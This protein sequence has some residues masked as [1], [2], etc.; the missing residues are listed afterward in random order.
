MNNMKDNKNQNF[1]IT[2]TD[3]CGWL[4]ARELY[5]A[6]L[7]PNLQIF[8]GSSEIPLFPNPEN[9]ENQTFL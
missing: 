5:I 2:K 9:F 6:T 3:V 8:T 4:L 1:Q 7:N